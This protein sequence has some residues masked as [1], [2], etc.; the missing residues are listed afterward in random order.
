MRKVIVNTSPLQ[1]LHQLGHLE[2]LQHLYGKIIAPSSVIGELM[3]GAEQGI[4]VPHC[5]NYAWILKQAVRT[6]A[7]LPLVPRLGAGEKEAIA[8]ALEE[9]EA[10][11]NVLVIL[12]DGLARR[13]AAHAGLAITG[14]LGILLKA[15]ERGHIKAIMPL[16]E[17][18]AQFGFRCD[19]TTREH[20]RQ[21]SGE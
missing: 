18:L 7:Y 19:A 11:N 10:G 13:F 21:L 8:L 4:D 14:T 15:R 3:R 16:V 12:D 6:R 9:Q 20:I 5:E 1:Y 17:R 2:V